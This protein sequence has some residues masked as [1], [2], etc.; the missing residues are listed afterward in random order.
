MS[1]ITFIYRLHNQSK[2]FYG[3]VNLC[4]LSDDH[5]GLDHEVRIILM[6]GINAYRAMKKM[7]ALPD[8]AKLQVGILSRLTLSQDHSSDQEVSCFDFYAKQQEGNNIYY[9]NGRKIE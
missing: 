2:A 1:A 5:K 9:V 7:T 6:E 3:K 8:D 4:T